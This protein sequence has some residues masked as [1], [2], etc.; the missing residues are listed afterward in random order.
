MRR[1]ERSDLLFKRLFE[2]QSSRTQ[3]RLEPRFS[4]PNHK[5]QMF[6][7]LSNASPKLSKL[8]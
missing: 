3:R 2:A 8:K 7:L 6:Y 1:K 4:H 5:T